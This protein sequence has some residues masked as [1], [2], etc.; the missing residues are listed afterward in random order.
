MS[1]YAAGQCNIGGAE[2]RQR[3]NAAWFTAITT[4]ILIA[5]I[6]A[7]DT[8]RAIRIGLFLPLAGTV[9]T[10]EQARRRFCLAYGWR[11]VFSF[12]RLGDVSRVNDDMAR[13]ADLSLVKQILIR[14][15]VIALA[16]TAMIYLL[17]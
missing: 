13:N 2:V 3:R 9:I 12:E 17:P 6:L 16:L 14:A 8:D 5:L 11:G 4:L 1:E 10:F 15:S 7:S